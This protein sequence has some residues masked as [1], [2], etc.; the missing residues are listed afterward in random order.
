MVPKHAEKTDPTKE[1]VTPHPTSEPE[2]EPDPDLPRYYDSEP[3]SQPPRYDKGASPA[4]S[5]LQPPA[6]SQ[7]Q[8][9][10]SGV[11][12]STVAALLAPAELEEKKTLRERWR[13][14]R[15]RN[16]DNN[17][18]SEHP[19]WWGDWRGSSSEWNVKGATISGYDR[20]RR[21]RLR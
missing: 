15:E 12:A 11:P 20:E 8:N 10:G 2:P 14:F 9:T 4:V 6:R 21:R 18:N 17:S 3:S 7:A 19:E 13:D 16:F 1:S 5:N